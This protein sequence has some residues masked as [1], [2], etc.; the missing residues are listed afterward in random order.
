M[1]I[2]VVGRP[3]TT[4]SLPWEEDSKYRAATVQRGSNRPMECSE[5]YP[6]QPLTET[7][8]IGLKYEAIIGVEQFDG[9]KETKT[10]VQSCAC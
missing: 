3:D 6:L 9:L 8:P 5:E 10:R 2:S 7:I 1:G 4:S